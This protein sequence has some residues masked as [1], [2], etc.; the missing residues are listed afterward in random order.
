M[1]ETGRHP[2]LTD[3][4]WVLKRAAELILEQTEHGERAA[5]APPGAIPAG[6]ILTDAE[7]RAMV[8]MLRRVMTPEQR[9]EAAAE[10]GGPG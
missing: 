4:D 3:P 8:K 6:T 5:D 1:S 10:L 9:R 2:A 7:A